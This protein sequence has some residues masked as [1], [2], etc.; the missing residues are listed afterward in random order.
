MDQWMVF[1]H[2]ANKLPSH[3]A[4]Q[5]VEPLSHYYSSQERLHPIKLIRYI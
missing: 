5:F 2:T 1:P 4:R 3:N